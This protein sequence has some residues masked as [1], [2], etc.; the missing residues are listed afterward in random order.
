MSIGIDSPS[1]EYVSAC[2]TPSETPTIRL[3]DKPPLASNELSEAVTLLSLIQDEQLTVRE[4]AARLKMSVRTV[5]RRLELV[6]NDTERGVVKLLSAKALDFAEDWSKASMIA[7]GKGDH[8]PAKDA[9]LAVKAIEPVGDQASTN[10]AILI[11]TPE[12][13][14]RISPPTITIDPSST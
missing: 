3:A 4:A 10:I 12:Q 8:R 2:A 1:L 7:A 14:I 11:G 9:L 6:E 5:F 13:P